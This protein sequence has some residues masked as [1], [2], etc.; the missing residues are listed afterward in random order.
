MVQP[1]NP[2]YDTWDKQILLHSALQDIVAEQCSADAYQKHLDSYEAHTSS[3]SNVTSKSK[4][5]VALPVAIAAVKEKS[6]YPAVTNIS[7]LPTAHCLI[8]PNRQHLNSDCNYQASI[9]QQKIRQ[10]QLIIIVIQE[11]QKRVDK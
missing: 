2:Q 7:I 11:L 6:T 8:H 3:S 9:R 10:D 4:T 5:L 1:D